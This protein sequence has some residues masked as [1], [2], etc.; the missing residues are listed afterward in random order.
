MQNEYHDPLMIEGLILSS[1]AKALRM[2]VILLLG[3]IV[4]KLVVYIDMD[5]VLANFD[6]CVHSPPPAG[7]S[8]PSEMLHK[9]FFRQLP[10]MTGAKNAVEALMQNP[11]LEIYIATKI[12]T[13]N[14]HAATEK[15][16]W[17]EEHFPALVKNV[18][19]ACDKTKLRGDILIDDFLRWKNFH[20][21][22][23]HFDHQNPE[24]SWQEAL[25][26]VQ[27]QLVD[28]DHG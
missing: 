17:L 25:T 16:Q 4:K 8:L 20:G 28:A 10:V 27:S 2:V 18:F 7:S 21:A 9:G 1:K 6:S 23:F 12:S 19:I 3:P 13:K 26:F 5:G 11:R 24:Q 15:L 22:F 14:L